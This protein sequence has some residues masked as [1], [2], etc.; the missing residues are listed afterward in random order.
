M[1]PNVAA[2]GCGGMTASEPRPPRDWKGDYPRIDDDHG[3]DCPGCDRLRELAK[4][5]E[6]PTCETCGGRFELFE[7]GADHGDWS[8]VVACRCPC[9]TLGWAWGEP[10]APGGL[11]G[12]DEDG[13]VHCAPEGP[14]YMAWLEQEE[15]KMEAEKRATAERLGVPFV[16]FTI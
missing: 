9:P 3:C 12:W 1:L 14:E 13:K 2:G 11:L 15:K 7:D 16:P 4:A 10:V 5:G 8:W 6:V